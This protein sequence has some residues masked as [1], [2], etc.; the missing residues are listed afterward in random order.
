MAKEKVLG[1]KH[2]IT[3][4]RPWNK[5]MYDHNDEVA[6]QMKGE[7]FKALQ[8]ARKGDDWEQMHTIAKAIVAYGYSDSYSIE[9]IH[10]DALRQLDM[11]QNYWLHDHC[12]PDLLKEG[13]VKPIEIEFV[14]YDK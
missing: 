6:K 5:E 4:T 10:E 12:W 11:T 2:G 9:E 8:L 13:L 14:G 7:I 3:I 1:T